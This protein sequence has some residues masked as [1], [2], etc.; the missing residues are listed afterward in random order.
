MAKLVKPSQMTMQSQ[1]GR[2]CD[3]K[4]RNLKLQEQQFTAQSSSTTANLPEFYS[5][6]EKPVRP[7]VLEQLLSARQPPAQPKP[8]SHSWAFAVQSR[9]DYYKST[10]NKDHI[11]S[12]GYYMPKYD[13]VFKSS[14]TLRIPPVHLHTAPMYTSRPSEEE[15]RPIR[16]LA[17]PSV[18]FELQLK[19]PDITS[20][21]PDVSDK[22]FE[23]LPTTTVS[24]SVRKPKT[25]DFSK[26]LRRPNNISAHPHPRYNPKYTLVFKKVVPDI[27][28]GKF[29][30]RPDA[31]K[32]VSQ[33]IQLSYRNVKFSQ[34]SPRGRMSE[35]LTSRPTSDIF[36]THMVKVNNRTSLTVLQE[37][38]LKMNGLRSSSVLGP[39]SS[40]S[41]KR[42][43]LTE[44]IPAN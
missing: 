28:F 30:S 22:R 21:A 20:L 27:D 12:T 24:S 8:Q 39:R 36:P 23:L 33:S 3:E 2:F 7:S 25:V 14:P 9:A 10:G 11:P 18:P 26:M 42:E 37:S 41:V 44:R 6:R 29:T 32:H 15:E 13:S 16:R 17:L 1:P 38:S 34:T 31:H 43:G 40:Y 35:F 19:R 4:Y 5:K